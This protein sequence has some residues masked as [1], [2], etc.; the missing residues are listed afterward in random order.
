MNI[1]SQSGCGKSYMFFQWLKGKLK[2]KW[3]TAE[4]TII[5]A[6]NYNSDPSC[7]PFIKACEKKHPAFQ[8]I[9]CFKEID[10]ELLNMLFYNQE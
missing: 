9:N 2:E 10:E 3:I 4:R 5:F 7:Q 1:V 8:K 6:Y